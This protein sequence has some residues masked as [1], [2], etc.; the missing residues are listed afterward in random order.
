MEPEATGWP[1]AAAQDVHHQDV[2]DRR[3]WRYPQHQ[4]SGFGHG[5]DADLPVQRDPAASELAQASGHVDAEGADVLGR[6][7]DR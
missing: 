5:G 7:L 1:F 2:P 6:N 3:R 4:V